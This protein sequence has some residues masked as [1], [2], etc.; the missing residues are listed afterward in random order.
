MPNSTPILNTNCFKLSQYHPNVP[1]AFF[2]P[3]HPPLQ[4][5]LLLH[6][7]AQYLAPICSPT[8]P[9]PD[10]TTPICSLHATKMPA[11]PPIPASFKPAFLL[12][13][14][15]PLY[16]PTHHSECSYYHPNLSLP[17]FTPAQPSKPRYYTVSPPILP[18]KPS[19]DPIESAQS[20]PSKPSH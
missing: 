10:T 16:L 3:A 7:S 20:H 15:S 2:K 11:L 18:F 19:H 12:I 14:L 5:Q 13:Q 6:Q 4:S 8:P 9:N 17:C 1:I